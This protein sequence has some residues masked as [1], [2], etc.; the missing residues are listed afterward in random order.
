[1]TIPFWAPDPGAAAREVQARFPGE[2]ARI[3]QRAREICRRTF[4]FQDPWEMERTSEPVC[5]DGPIDWVSTPNGDAE[6]VYALNRH[7]TFL[8]LARAWRFTGDDAFAHAFS[9]QMIDW[10]D[11]VP[12][13]SAAESTAWRALEAG[14][15]CE[16]WLRALQLFEGAP[17]PEK[18]R[19]A[20]E[21]SL[22]EHGRFLVRSH[23]PFQKLSN[24]GVL[25]DHGLF[26]LGLYFDQA[27]W[28]AL[29]LARM[30]ENLQNA[31]LAD[32]VQWEQSPMYHCEVLQAVS[33]TV[34]NARR[35][36]TPLPAGFED[37]VHRM[38]IALAAWIKPDGRLLCQSDSDAID[39]RGLLAKG[40]LLF[41]DR[42][43]HAAVGDMLP[44][45]VLWDFG[46]GCAEFFAAPAA[47]APADGIVSKALPDSGNYM[48]RA[49]P[50]KDTAWLHLHGGSLG[51]G[52]GHAD[53]LHIDLYHRGEDVL[54]DAGRGTYVDGPL[55]RR[56]KSPAA[57]NTLRLDGQDFTVYRDTWSWAQVA[58]P[59]PAEY[60]FTPE[61]DYLCAGHL[62]YGIPVQRKVLFLKPDI[63]VLFDL[64]RC[65]GVHTVEQN[66]QFGPGDLTVQGRSA[67][68]QG[69]RAQ[70]H[71][72]FLHSGSAEPYRGEVSPAYNT[73][74]FAPALRVQTQ[75]E[76]LCPLVT[77][78]SL[79]TAILAQL[80]PV[81][82]PGGDPLPPS[83]AQA[84]RLEKGG[85]TCTVLLTHAAGPWDAGL[86]S[87]GGCSGHGR[88][89]VFTPH[90]PGGLCLA[91]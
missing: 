88:A 60:R 72:Q 7:T 49:A 10:L 14:L 56:L 13:T 55:R 83:A 9:E 37:D 50:G 29:A 5:F 84:V 19:P 68:W 73:L 75:V 32:G 61:A 76:G 21:E 86:L 23:G 62:G 43:L 58:T 44:C 22:Q 90:T 78:I 80:L 27:R 47:A 65:K 64:C 79:D 35:T 33:D 2:A 63:F 41:G 77:V 25:Q 15:R 48:L 26:L 39:A 82:T 20:A 54:L 4:V 38:F 1:M 91:R 28:T 36:G 87:A 51:G 17:L 46:P 18:L 16:N 24:W 70:A 67:R 53:L 34:L 85:Q 12:H 8:N 3:V 89:L 81:T 6:W 59:L 31:L 66:F 71:L 30:A 57:H 74:L 69:R 11:R 52:H 42:T 45:E 40:A